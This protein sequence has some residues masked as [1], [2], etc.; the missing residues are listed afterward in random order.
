VVKKYS[1]PI[2]NLVIRLTGQNQDTND[3]TQE[4]FIKVFESLDRFDQNKRFFPWL[5]TIALNVIRNY[6]KKAIKEPTLNLEIQDAGTANRSLSRPDVIVSRKQQAER[7]NQYIQ[8]LPESLQEAIVLRYYQDCSFKEIADV[9]G[10]SLS[11]AKMRVY[12]GLKALAER[13]GE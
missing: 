1:K 2:Y 10:V 12:R 6:K 7:L 4:I 13:I 8:G 3:L 5:Y 9:L 11:A